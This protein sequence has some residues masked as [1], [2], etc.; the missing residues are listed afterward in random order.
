M[1]A[2][3]TGSS[4]FLGRHFT[5]A[6]EEHGYE[7]LPL[8]TQGAGI[9][10][11]IRDFFRGHLTHFDLV[12]HC[13]ALV[14]GRET[15]EHKAALIGAYNLQLDAAL[16]EWALRAKPGRILYISSSAAYPTWLQHGTHRLVETDAGVMGA[17]DAT[18]GYVKRVGER[19]AEEVRAAGVPVTVIR[20]FSGY[21]EDQDDCYP[22]PAIIRRARNLDSPFTVWGDGKQVRDF[23]HV[24]DIVSATLAL[25]DAHVDGPVNIGTGVATSM[26]DLAWLAMTAAGY[27]APIRHLTDK[28]QGV[29]YRVADTTLMR[30]Y[31]TPQV[32]LEEGIKRALHA[33]QA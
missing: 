16:W 24:D 31:Y 28:P 3:V 9:R 17:P 26:D 33:R 1:R 6:L 14:D 18:Y 29:R 10:Y 7:V 4:G 8:D 27:H 15:I 20:P 12:V 30:R 5:T 25:I 21:G 13:A 32:T 11:D 23:I 22:F 2:L 19:L